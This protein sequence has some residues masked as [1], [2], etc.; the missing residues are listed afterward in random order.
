M[1]PI[2][3]QI[4]SGGLCFFV[5]FNIII[6]GG[7]TQA[8]TKALKASI[9]SKKAIKAPQV[10][11][12]A[13]NN[14]S[15]NA[16]SISISPPTTATLT[17]SSS[18]SVSSMKEAKEA[19]LYVDL[20]IYR[21]SGYF[22]QTTDEDP[23]A[24]TENGVG[25][26]FRKSDSFNALR[27][28]FNSKI[29][30]SQT[31]S[32]SVRNNFHEYRSFYLRYFPMSLYIAPSQSTFVETLSKSLVFLGVGLGVLTPETEMK[33]QNAARTFISQSYLLEAWMVG[34]NFKL[35][36]QFFLETFLQGSLAQPY[37]GGSISSLGLDLGYRF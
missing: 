18:L 4:N 2:L 10:Y 37:P 27:L 6:F 3:N 31:G 11:R 15:N 8:S 20:S 32:L 25:V 34:I 24:F 13:L 17:P 36:H 5:C 35:E 29:R 12:L 30:H 1:K 9:A 33:A 14:N 22:R 26:N 23:L 21:S 28:D 19:M 16:K 7:V